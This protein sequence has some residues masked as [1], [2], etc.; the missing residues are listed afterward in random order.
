MVEEI[1]PAS[2]SHF[3]SFHDHIIQWFE[4]FNQTWVVWFLH[5]QDK[6]WTSIQIKASSTKKIILRTIRQH[7]PVLSLIKAH[8]PQT[9]QAKGK[10]IEILTCYDEIQG[11]K[12]YTSF[13]NYRSS[14]KKPD[15]TSL[16]KLS[17]DNKQAQFHLKFCYLRMVQATI[18]KLQIRDYGRDYSWSSNNVGILQWKKKQHTYIL[19]HINPCNF[20]I[21]CTSLNKTYH[22]NSVIVRN[23]SSTLCNLT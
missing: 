3:C 4:K 9:F 8:K 1:R 11:D 17:K 22:H 23:L 18:P 6:N 13:S 19:H 5:N 21:V 2:F 14:I 12:V 20:T 15:S 16:F 10:K 7:L